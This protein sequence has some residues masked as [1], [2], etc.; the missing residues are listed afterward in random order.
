MPIRGNGAGI[1][2]Q[3]IV[4]VHDAFGFAGGTGSKGKI[5]KG[6]GIRNHPSCRSI[7]I[8][9][10]HWMITEKG[11]SGVISAERLQGIV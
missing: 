2:Q 8:G 4:T 11:D 5:D 9:I 10:R 3:G 1:G 7:R 6:I